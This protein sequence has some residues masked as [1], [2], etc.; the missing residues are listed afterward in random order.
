MID[1]VVVFDSIADGVF[2]FVL[3]MTTTRREGFSLCTKATTLCAMY[4]YAHIAPF[5]VLRAFTHIGRQVETPTSKD[6][7]HHLISVKYVHL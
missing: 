1:L 2:V 7:K 5:S 4:F 6:S 3:P